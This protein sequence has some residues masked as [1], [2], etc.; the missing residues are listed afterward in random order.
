VDADVAPVTVAAS[1]YVTLATTL[2]QRMRL[3]EPTGGVWEA[4]D[5]QWW[6]RQERASDL[7]GQLFWLDQRGEPLAAVVRTDFGRSVQCDV[8]VLP[9]DPE[10]QRSVWRTAIRKADDS[11]KAVEFPVRADAAACIAELAAAGF[12]AADDAVV[13]SW[14]AAESRPAIR[15]LPPGYRLLS[16]AD[17]KDRPHPLAKRNGQQVE[18]RLRRCSLY[19]PELDLMVAAPD[20][21]A[22]GYGLFWAD[23]VTGVGLVEP[24]RTEEAHQRLGIAAHVLATG[25]ERLADSGCQRFKVSNDIDLY[26]R[27]GFRPLR[28]ATAAVYA[29]A[30]R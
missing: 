29:R 5:V 26:L 30:H 18:Q 3:A 28:S 13:T 16:R 4:A 23:P 25:L 7:D 6:S 24:M 8:L 12:H 10:W 1:D 22:A 9:D 19:R 2:L 15:V 21:Q 14:L 27:A 11:E 17:D 20:G